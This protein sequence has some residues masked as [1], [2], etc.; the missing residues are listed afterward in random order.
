MITAA[1]IALIITGCS[2]P[3]TAKTKTPESVRLEYVFNGGKAHSYLQTA[4]TDQ[5]MDVQGQ[6]VSVSTN[7]Y[8]KFGTGNFDS[9]PGLF[10]F[11]VVIDS[12]SVS[13]ISPMMDNMGAMG[14]E[15][16]GK[17]FRMTINSG[18][19]PMSLG[20]AASI[21]VGGSVTG[22]GDIGSTFHEMFPVLPLREVKAGESWTSA[23]TISYKSGTMEMNTITK[24][25]YTFTG[26]E[27]LNERTCA[28]VTGTIEGTRHA[29]MNT[30]GM[31][32]LMSVPY[33]GTETI[34]FDPAEGIVV[35]Y[36]SS[37]S[38]SGQIEVIGMGM[39]LDVSTTIKGK[40][41]LIK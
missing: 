40:L 30:Q 23:D 28:V 25:N 18:G 36:E 15:A 27:V 37:V 7:S 22:G 19:K 33:K 13:V 4:V 38:G 3:K 16:N 14:S 8:L 39:N 31:D 10:E 12:L 21:Q 26:F 9:R 32:M 6:S 35:K 17:S 5:Y 29:K 34:W 1:V 2:A 24:G 41:E 11:D 20:N